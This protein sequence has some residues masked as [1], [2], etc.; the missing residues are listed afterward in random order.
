MLFFLLQLPV[1]MTAMVK[2]LVIYQKSVYV[3]MVSGEN[4]VNPVSTFIIWAVTCDF[5]QYGM[6]DVY[7]FDMLFIVHAR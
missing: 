5:Q 1:R 3:T 7:L 2:E 6:Y 4:T